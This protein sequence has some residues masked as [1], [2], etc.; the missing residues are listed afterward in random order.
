[1]MFAALSLVLAAHAEEEEED[2]VNAEQSV[3]GFTELEDAEAGSPGNFEERAWFGM[4]YAPDEGAGP[5]E[6]IELSYTGRGLLQYSEFDFGE[7]LEHAGDES[8]SGLVFGWMQRWVKDGGRKSAVPSVGTLTE[9]DLRTPGLSR[10]TGFA[11]GAEAG[12]HLGE[13]LTV[14]KYAGPGTLYVN[15]EIQAQLFG[16]PEYAPVTF[17]ARIGYKAPIVADVLDLE[18]DVTHETSELAGPN[19][20]SESANVAAIWHLG[21]HWTVSPGVVVSVDDGDPAPAVEA[22]VFLLHE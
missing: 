11:A 17:A 5:S 14:A 9:Y 21:E 18:V 12:D 20:A 16:T 6:T 15:G 22:G 13:I 7:H 4:G 10:M 3:D 1:M 2:I 19:P 8:A